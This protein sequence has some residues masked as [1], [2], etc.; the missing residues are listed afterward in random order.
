MKKII[1]TAAIIIAVFYKGLAQQDP[2]LTQ[3]MFNHLLINPGYAGSKDYAMT[4]LLYRNQWVKLDG[5]PKSIV[6]TIHGPVFK[7][8]KVGLGFTLMNDNIGITNRTNIM[9]DYAYHIP[10]KNNLKLAVGLKAGLMNHSAKL[11]DAIIIDPTDKVYQGGTVSKL[12]PNVGA[13]AYLYSKKFY[14]GLSVPGFLSYDP[15]RPISIDGSVRNIPGYVR[16]YWITSGVALEAS[17]DF[18]VRPS[19]MLR[20]TKNAPLQA[21]LNCNTLIKQFLWLGATFRTGDKIAGISESIIGIVQL[22]LNKQFRIGYS[23]DFTT[24]AL[25]NYSN[26]SHELMLGYDFG[27]DILKMRSPRYF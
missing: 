23:Y 8:R 22:Q 12:N 21:D 2:L 11:S 5:A 25:N 1:L 4:T 19:I 24:T 10:I 13:G 27:Y 18:V 26:G 17:P 6:A 14:L 16:H 7:S 15:T 20:Y 3:Y 9:V